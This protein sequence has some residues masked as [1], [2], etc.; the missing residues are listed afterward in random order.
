MEPVIAVIDT[1][2]LGTFD[3]SIILSV[4][5]VVADLSER[6]RISELCTH[7][8]AFFMKL[9]A[10]EQIQKY[11]RVFDSGTTDWW[12][13]VPS[14]EAKK[15][16]FTPSSEDKS[17]LEL[18]PAVFKYFKEINVNPKRI[19]WY[20]R[21]AFDLSKLEH[22][23]KVST[24]RSKDIFWHYINRREV[25]SYLEGLGCDNRYGDIKP[26]KIPSELVYHNP[27]H[28]SVVDFIRIQIALEKLGAVTLD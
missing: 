12:K 19:L 13:T 20:D 14:E 2:T 7:P 24:N 5:I 16:S 28:D 8:H 27:V 1:E 6:Y 21:N 4:G 9:D 22:F 3:N 25:V 10:K 17:I 23:Y 11:N 18:S 26:D 15:L